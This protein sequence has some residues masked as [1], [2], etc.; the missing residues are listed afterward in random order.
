LF[1]FLTYIR[2]L[3][4]RGEDLPVQID[5]VESGTE[6]ID[7]VKLMSIHK[8]K[9]LEFPIVFLVNTSKQHNYTDMR[10]NA[11]FHSELGIGS[12]LI[13][14]K[15]RTR[16]S[17]L[18]RDAIRHKLS[19][20]MLSEELR[21]LYVAM[22]R[23]K[24]KL[25]IT[26]TFRNAKQTLAKIKALPSGK[27]AP[28]AMKSLRSTGEWILAGLQCKASKECVINELDASEILLC[29]EAFDAGSGAKEE[30]KTSEEMS[31]A[32]IRPDFYFTYPFSHAIDLPSKLT[33]TGL[34]NMADSESEQAPWLKDIDEIYKLK[35]LPALLS[36]KNISSGAEH[37]TLLHLV[38]QHIDYNKGSDDSEISKELQHMVKA[39]LLSEEQFAEINIKQIKRLLN[40]DL[41]SRM[42]SG[43][44]LKR[45]FRFSL[46]APAKQ[47][48]PGSGNEPILLQGIIDCF[49]EEDNEL[50]IVDFKS[51]KVT[52]HTLSEK[53]DRY[54]QQLDAYADALTR[55]T[56]KRVK[57][58][59]IYFFST[60][61]AVSV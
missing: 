19:D 12:M 56:G 52:A 40:S 5:G 8:S 27:V 43:K 51:D 3:Q 6:S 7:A 15:L 20:E 4:D 37:G 34:V 30:T 29:E 58:R 55:I 48:Y 35:P 54:S 47:F 39:G 28:L 21:V 16:H 22:T 2:S 25:F 18:A 1:G 44:G 50:V 49:F 36:E 41:G 38:M 10:K 9:G 24:E 11:V 23:A 57:E 60:D 33:V 17:T 46:L 14:K 31:R 61:T 53:V 13:N 32:E 26:A 45:E 59:I 42:I